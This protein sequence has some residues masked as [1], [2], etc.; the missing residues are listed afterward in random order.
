[1]LASRGSQRLILDAEP[2][3]G[4]DAGTRAM[5]IQRA[6]AELEFSQLAVGG[7]QAAHPTF[8]GHFLSLVGWIQARGEMLL[9]SEPTPAKTEGQE[10]EPLKAASRHASGSSGNTRIASTP[11]S[12]AAAD[13]HMASPP[14]SW[15]M[16]PPL[17][18]T[19]YI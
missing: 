19:S 4:G 8:Q 17:R 13:L 11:V 9:R 16:A 10:Q 3:R 18:R 12:I 1:M 15:I 6:D 7:R 5:A 2:Y 14:K